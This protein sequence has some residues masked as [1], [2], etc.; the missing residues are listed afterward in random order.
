MHSIGEWLRGSFDGRG[1]DRADGRLFV[2]DVIH[3]ASLRRLSIK[4]SVSFMQAKLRVIRSFTEDF[5]KRA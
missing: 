4:L 1:V 2:A 5:L 3:M